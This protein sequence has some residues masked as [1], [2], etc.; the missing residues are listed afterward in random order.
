MSAPSKQ[1]EV[2]SDQ[3]LLEAFIQHGDN[4][5]FEAI[6]NRHGPMVFGI[7]RRMLLNDHDAEDAFQA[8]FLVLA[9][10]APSVNPPDMLAN[11]LSGVAKKTALHARSRNRKRQS[12]EKTI[13]ASPHRVVSEQLGSADLRPILEQEVYRLPAK[14]R[15]CIVLCDLQG[16]TRREASACLGWPEG[17]LSGRL[18]RARRMLARRLSHRGLT[19]AVALGLMSGLASV[20]PRSSVLESTVKIALST[21]T[22]TSSGSATR[23]AALAR[24]IMKFRFFEM[25]AATMAV[26]II[27]VGLAIAI[28]DK[29]DPELTLAARSSARV[30]NGRMQEFEAGRG[31]Q[32]LLLLA[33]TTLLN[34][35]LEQAKNDDAV[36]DIRRQHF[37]RMVRIE[38]VDQKRYEQGRI[39]ESDYLEARFYRLKAELELTRMNKKREVRVGYWKDRQ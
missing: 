26:L 1:V 5:S 25:A 37:D 9:R 23:V 22:E 35:Q 4:A 32:T 20:P 28:R 3:Q 11:W 36:R 8:T 16:M 7:C 34:V 18:A 27:L 14:Y 17:T 21:S 38:E 24:A 29:D 31:S 15:I 30:V 12:R 39:A 2:A 33:A 10:K 13:A 19:P 6:V